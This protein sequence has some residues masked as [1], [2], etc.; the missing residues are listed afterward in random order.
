M[1]KFKPITWHLPRPSPY[2]YNGSYPLNFESKFRKFL[3]FAD[4]LHVFSGLA[5]SGLRVDLK[6]ET[7][8]DVVADAHHLPFRDNVFKAVLAD[9]PYSDQYA[10]EL[11]QTPKLSLKKYCAEFA[12][13]V[14]NGGIIAIYH[15]MIVPRP[16]QCNYLG[17]IAII[18]GMFHK[19]R[20]VSIFQKEGEGQNLDRFIGPD[21]LE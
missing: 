14:I 5:K 13:V 12:R 16:A 18:M 4:Y 2:R 7:R 6:I 10:K 15:L 1:R 21:R 17:A 3:G 20:I 19:A 11:Y 8:P 9:P